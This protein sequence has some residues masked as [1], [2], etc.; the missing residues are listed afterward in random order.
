MISQ[1]T[2]HRLKRQCGLTLIEVMAALAIFA[3][4]ALAIVSATG[5]H[6]RSLTY[7]EQKNMALWVANN[8]LTQLTLDD[9]FPQLGDKKGNVELANVTWYWQQKVVKTAD[10]KFRSITI[11]ILSEEKAD[12]ALAELTTYMASKS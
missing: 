7:L 1:M 12:Y 9:K 3:V 10:P 8:H 4:A 11:R 6:I 2:V 5:E